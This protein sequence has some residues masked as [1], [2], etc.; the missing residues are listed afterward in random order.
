MLCQWLWVLVFNQAPTAWKVSKYGVVSGPNKGKYTPKITLVFGYFSC[1]VLWLCW[2][3]V[4]HTIH[5]PF[6]GLLTPSS[7]ELT[8]FLNSA[9]KV[10]WLQVPPITLSHLM[11]YFFWSHN[12]L[13][14]K[15]WKNNFRLEFSDL[16]LSTT[17]LFTKQRWHISHQEF[18][19]DITIY[20]QPYGYF[21]M[22][23]N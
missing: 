2:I 23:Q 16:K 11:P 3:T 1:S 7:V 5:P 10:A 13:F 19:Q 8:L 21:F 17:L 22:I 4:G 14:I 20:L 6:E 18:I 15:T 9:F 12:I